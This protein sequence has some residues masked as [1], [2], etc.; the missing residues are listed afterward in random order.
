L[1]GLHGKHAVQRGIWVS[2]S[3]SES[4]DEE[5]SDDNTQPVTSSWKV[6]HDIKF[7]YSVTQQEFTLPQSA[8]P[9]TELEY[10]QLI[11]SDDVFGEIVTATNMYAAEK[12][13][14]VTMAYLFVAQN[15]IPGIALTELTI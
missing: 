10:L 1:G 4:N 13:Q 8:W 2:S 7:P 14:N 6:Y 15:S 3:E 12:I 9:K 5:E 11:F